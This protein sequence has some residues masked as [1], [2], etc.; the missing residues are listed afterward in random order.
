[1]ESTL[2][3]AA[4]NPRD[5]SADLLRAVL[6]VYIVG[7]LHLGGYVGSGNHHVHWSTVALTNV[8]LGTFTFLSGYMLGNWSGPIDIHGVAYFYKR[9]F[10]RIYPLY[11]LALIGFVLVWLTDAQTAV[12]A[13]LGL[14]MF[15][16]PAPMTLWYVAMIVVCYALAP[17]LI[18]PTVMRALTYGMAVWSFMLVYGF[19]VVEMDHRMLTQFAAFAAGVMCRRLGWR[20]QLRNH[21]IW[22][23][24]GFAVALMVA[25]ISLH[26]PLLGAVMAVP[27]VV[28]GPLLLLALADRYPAEQTPSAWVRSLAYTSFTAYLF[29]RIFFTLLQRFIWPADPWLQ[30]AVLVG[31][32]LPI[33]WAGSLLIQWAYDR[34]LDLLSG[35]RLL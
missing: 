17:L 5:G 10:L 29:H 24:V 26:R 23:A 8:V 11:I 30:V 12:K 14:S 25:V 20:E 16:P 4:A 1:V 7:Y 9:R 35:N 2:K 32:G 33:I 21:P 13:A 18:V 6:V 27:S 19:L 3:S 22:L 34:M 31:F 15:I 28:V